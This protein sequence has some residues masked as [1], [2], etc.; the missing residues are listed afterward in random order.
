MPEARGRRGSGRPRRR[1]RPK[2]RLCRQR[3]YQILHAF[4][5]GGRPALQPYQTTPKSNYRRTGQAVRQ[6]LRHR[7]LD[8]EAS[9]EV[10]AQELCQTHVPIS[11]RSVQRVLAEDG[12]LEA[13]TVEQAQPLQIELGQRRRSSGHF[14]GPVLA[15]DPPRWVSDS[16]RDRGQ[17][18][19]R[20]TEPATQ[21]APTFFLVDA[22]D[23]RPPTP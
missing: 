22:P 23:R 19:P 12:L 13:H 3:Y 2:I 7:F 6:I 17:R 10:L 8:S 18:R 15:L 1:P 4:Q 14:P 11:Q 21:P 5:Q 20:A 9:P 16:K